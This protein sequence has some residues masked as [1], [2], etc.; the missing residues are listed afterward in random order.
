MPD[1][2]HGRQV[3]DVPGLLQR[4]FDVAGERQADVVARA[5]RAGYQLSRQQLSKLAAGFNRCPEAETVRALAAG[6]RT[7][8]REVWLAVG[9]SLGLDVGT[10][11]LGDRIEPGFAGLPP[12]V[13]D[14]ITLMLRSLTRAAAHP[15]PYAPAP[16]VTARG[17]EGE[18]PAVVRWPKAKAPSRRRAHPATDPEANGGRT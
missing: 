8:E 6:L 14:A 12:D 5:Q 18:G 11:D 15:G 17:T 1:S 9:A 7:T 4:H 16:G 3:P 13:Q 2:P 10:A